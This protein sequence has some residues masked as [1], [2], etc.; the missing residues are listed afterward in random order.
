MTG[1]A[2]NHY[3]FSDAA[4]AIQNVMIYATAKNLGSCFI[5]MASFIEKDKDLMRELHIAENMKIA[6]AVIVGYP[7]ETPEPKEKTLKAEYFK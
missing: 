2:D 5:G 4:L 3:I 1:P 6:G 7:D